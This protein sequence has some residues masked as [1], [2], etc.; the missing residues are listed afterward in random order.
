MDY[1]WVIASGMREEK[2]ED[3]KYKNLKKKKSKH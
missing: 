2:S 3:G 1:E